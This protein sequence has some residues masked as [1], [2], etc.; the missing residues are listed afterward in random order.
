MSTTRRSFVKKIATGTAGITLGGIAMG[1]PLEEYWNAPFSKKCLSWKG[2]GVFPFAKYMADY[3][4]GDYIPKDQGGKFIQQEIPGTENDEIIVEKIR[5]GVLE[6]IYGNPID[7]GK[8]EKTELEKSVWLNRFYYL[9]SFARMYYLTGEKSYL[10][11][12]M[13]FISKWIDENP[14]VAENKQSK[15]NWYDMQV[16]WRSIHLSW[17]YFLAYKGLSEKDKTV[18]RNTLEEHVA[19]LLSGFGKQQLNEFNHQSHGALAMLYLGVLFPELPH[20]GEL[21]DTAIKILDHHINHAFYADGG[22]VEQ[23]FGYYPFE[24]HIFRDTFLLCKNNGIQLPINLVPLLHK[25]AHYLSAVAQPD[26]TMPPVNDSFAMS[27]QPIL[28]TL[29]DVLNTNFSEGMSKSAYFPDTQIGVFRTKNAGNSWYLLMN[30]ASTIGSH[31]HAGRLGFNLWYNNQPFIIDSGCC[32]YDDPM[33]VKWYRTSQAHNTVLIDGK[34]DEATSKPTQWA[35]KRKTGNR[36]IE[37]IEKPSYRF[38]RMVSP[39][40]EPVNSLVTWSRSLAIVQNLFVI[41]YDHFDASEEHDYEMLFHLPDDILVEEKEGTNSLLLKGNQPLALLPADEKIIS[42]TTIKKGVICVE[43]VN[44]PAPVISYQLQGAQAHSVMVFCPVSQ[45]VS[46]IKIEQK[47][48]GEGLGISF[49]NGKGEKYIAI[50]RSPNIGS[51]SFWGHTTNDLF[52]VF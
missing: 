20:A 46:E 43:G 45:F 4:I 38:C 36:I 15:Y 7:W 21:T 18:I 16:A 8:L 27:V 52:A 40:C 5:G 23:M 9:P 31:A 1:M 17:C 32:N 48:S 44:T 12:M 25:M 28:S 11:F 34:S 50:F 6:T 14:R 2:T 49:E 29:A 22:N 30:P 39:A 3:N 33:L 47:I 24:A 10:D 35:P 51:A 42:K 19:I 37:W 26:G 41:V 13:Q